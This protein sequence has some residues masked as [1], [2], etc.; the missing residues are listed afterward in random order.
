MFEFPFHSLNSVFRNVVNVLKVAF[1]DNDFRV[2]SKSEVRLKMGQLNERVGD[3]HVLALA[4]VLRDPI[5]A[6]SVG[7]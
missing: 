7:F 5:E 3:H 2:R 1:T 4:Q 6:I